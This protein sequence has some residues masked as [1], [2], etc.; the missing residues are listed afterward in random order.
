MW[1]L[2][3]LVFLYLIALFTVPVVRR[4]NLGRVF[5]WVNRW[6]AARVFLWSGLTFVT[7]L[8]MEFGL[9]DTPDGFRFQPHIVA[10]YCVFFFFGWALYHHRQLL[11]SFQRYAWTQV[12]LACGLSGANIA[13][14]IR[15][16]SARESGQPIS[17]VDFYGTA[18]TGALVVWL[19]VF[20]LIGLFLRYLDRP[21][22][23]WRYLSDSAYW[24]YLFHPPV[25]VLSQFAVWNVPIHWAWK[26]LFVSATS[27]TV[28]LWTYQAWVR[29][30]WL[31]VLLNGRRYSKSIVEIEEAPRTAAVAEA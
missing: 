12:A 28:L 2:E 15:Q 21:S 29:S 8:P 19:M 30:T 23:A 7:L 24:L 1:F 11:G 9:L 18:A 27:L 16:V 5:L 3:Y 17:A 26:L 13:F 4:L 20:G 14:A 10:A 31:G 6:P 22:P 25:V